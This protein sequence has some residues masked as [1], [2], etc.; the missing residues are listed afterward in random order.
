MQGIGE[1]FRRCR[2]EKEQVEKCNFIIELFLTFAKVEKG[3]L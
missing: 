1:A 3:L 2:K